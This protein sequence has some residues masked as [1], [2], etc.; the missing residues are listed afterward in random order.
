MSQNQC[1][2]KILMMVFLIFW[3][4]QGVVAAPDPALVTM[5][6]N[7]KKGDESTGAE[8]EAFKKKIETAYGSGNFQLLEKFPDGPYKGKNL[9]MALMESGDGGRGLVLEMLEDSDKYFPASTLSAVDSKKKN[10]LF[11]ALESKD[12]DIFNKIESKFN[13]ATDPKKKEEWT[14]A[15]K[16]NNAWGNSLLHTLLQNKQW[17]E[18]EKSKSEVAK[19]ADMLIKGGVNLFQ[20]NVYGSTSLIRA[21]KEGQGDVAKL[22]LEELALRK[23]EAKTKNDKK[24]LS[25]IR[26]LINQR[27]IFGSSALYWGVRK[28]DEP[29]VSQLTKAGAYASPPYWS[30][31]TK[32]EAKAVAQQWL[33][34][35]WKDYPSAIGV[36]LGVNGPNKK[37]KTSPFILEEKS[38]PTAKDD[39]EIDEGEEEVAAHS[40]C[41]PP[42]K[43]KSNSFIANLENIMTAMQADIGQHHRISRE[44]TPD[45]KRTAFE[46]WSDE[47]LHWF[48]QTFA[49]R[50][51]AKIN[52]D[53]DTELGADQSAQGKLK[54]KEL[55]KSKMQEKLY[56]MAAK[57]PVLMNDQITDL[58]SQ[59]NKKKSLLQE[60][61]PNKAKVGF[62]H[63]NELLLDHLEKYL[64]IIHRNP[65][66]QAAVG[67]IL[68][69]EFIVGNKTL[70]RENALNF[71]FDRA[72]KKNEEWALDQSKVPKDKKLKNVYF[73]IYS[74]LDNGAHYSLGR[75]DFEHEKILVYDSAQLTNSDLEK[76]YKFL[77]SYLEK[78]GIDQKT[79][80]NNWKIESATAKAVQGI[81]GDCGPYTAMFADVLIHSKGEL[82]GDYEQHY[83]DTQIPYM[84]LTMLHAHTHPDSKK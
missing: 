79:L 65:N 29:S 32:A 83:T 70:N 17:S 48:F 62:A 55:K 64:R 56:E 84:R 81:D 3:G 41:K 58:R 46:H 77:F 49:K 9:L 2:L 73:P 69:S 60:I 12:S 75:V 43:D 34:R 80:K 11:Y 8:G 35:F 36:N 22:I 30:S 18:N 20:E 53:I 51:L 63:N 28:Q 82:G 61:L 15:V 4:V 44:W 26:N 19:V 21:V 76:Y 38:A 78:M 33:E 74:K 52:Q 14:K 24:V 13:S 45:Q 68:G 71:K 40:V 39:E 72:R 7:I 27:N 42:P 25:E 57:M 47:N 5:L 59:V 10:L 50:Q 54:K 31:K 1:F 6:E 37:K 66:D 16:V 67:P 23:E